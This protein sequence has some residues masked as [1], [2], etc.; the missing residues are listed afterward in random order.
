MYGY[1]YAT[2]NELA[3]FDFIHGKANINNSI[4]TNNMV[5]GI[6]EYLSADRKNIDTE[7]IAF[8]KYYQRIYKG[9]GCIYKE[10]LDIIRDSRNRAGEAL[11]RDY[12][13]Q[14]PFI[15]FPKNSRH[16]LYIFGHSLDVTDKDILQDLILNDNIYT[17]IFYPDKKELGK[18]IANLVKVI[19]QDELIRRTGGSTKT[20]EFRKQQDV[21]G[22]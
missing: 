4:E 17:T 20:I 8:K 21:V 1:Y 13:T 6:D 16:K 9:T 5:L 10:W 19:G 3:R 15:K 14:I 7:F 22:V 18:K 11:K 2:T 12:P